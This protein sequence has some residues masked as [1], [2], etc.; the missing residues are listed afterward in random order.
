MN[1]LGATINPQYDQHLASLRQDYLAR[2]SEKLQHIALGWEQ[3]C[4]GEDRAAASENL[5]RA[6]HLL[7]G[8]AATFGCNA[9]ADIARRFE[10]LLKQAETVDWGDSELFFQQGASYWQWLNSAI[11][12]EEQLVLTVTDPAI[13]CSIKGD[14][15]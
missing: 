5:A 8:S 12:L 10:A 4:H 14:V 9:V 7:T 11:A 2:L 3:V 13:S 6:L 15:P 1:A